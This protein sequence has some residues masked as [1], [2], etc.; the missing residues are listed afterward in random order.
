LLNQYRYDSAAFVLVA[1]T[2]IGSS[3]TLRSKTVLVVEDE[4][5]LRL[6][7][8]D[9][10]EDAGFT[11]LEAATADAAILLLEA[12]P[13]IDL[14]FTDIDMPGSMDGMRLAAVVGRR[15]P[16]IRLS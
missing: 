11:V 1:A 6:G 15:W 5:L 8:V 14:L 16:P 10:L 13:S 7:I 2:Q 9:G 4:A 3:M 12:H